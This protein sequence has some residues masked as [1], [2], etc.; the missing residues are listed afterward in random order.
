MKQTDTRWPTGDGEM[1]TCIRS[2]D[3]L[4]TP[5]GPIAE[6][7][8]SLRTAVDMTLGSSVATV[9]LWGAALTQIYNDRWRVLMDGKHPAALGQPTHECFPEIVD[10][11]LPLYERARRG[12]AVILQD[13]LL[14]I[15]RDGEVKDAWWN[16][17]YLPVRDE[18]GAV[19][20]IFCTVI[21]TTVGVLAEQA[22]AGAVAA[23]RESEARFR[24]LATAG[25]YAVYRMSPDWRR[26]HR[27]DGRGFLADTGEPN[28][29]WADAYILPEDRSVVLAAIEAAIRDRRMFELEHRVRRA[30]GGVG[31]TH[32]RAVPIL[33]DDGEITEWF[34]TASDVTARKMSEVG[35]H[36]SE[37][38]FRH[39]V[40]ATSDIVWDIDLVA[41]RVWWSEA[42]QTEL[43][44]AEAEIGPDTAWCFAHMHPDDRKRVVASMKEAAAGTGCVW[45]DE[46]RYRRADGVYAHIADRGFITRDASGRALRMTGAMQDVTARKSA[47]AA[48]R[49][50][51][52]R[53]QLALDTA[54]LATWDW[55]IARDEVA[56]SDRHFHLQGYTV[57]GVPPSY[58]AWVARVHPED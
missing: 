17:H 9:L 28:E 18:H 5:L 56:W 2:H 15:T 37:E 29:A 58:D 33:A 13:T 8:T 36:E 44:F 16:V 26:M 19:T 25:S 43:G 22:Q 42:L 34:G 27:L 6:W 30:D 49:E 46:F 20:G 41:D 4:A 53:L 54:R 50:S 57:G 21:E 47:E 10:A 7:P 38:R 52:G 55:D 35:L 31:W 39:V 3:W 48:L 32:S 1:A 40:R 45:S 23:L 11:M 14:P 24:A 12:E 51:E